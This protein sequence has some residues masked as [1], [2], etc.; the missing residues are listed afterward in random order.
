MR[1]ADRRDARHAASG[2][3]LITRAAP[4]ALPRAERPAIAPAVVNLNFYGVPEHERAAIIRAIPGPA[5]D[6]ATEER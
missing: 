6:A 5:G 2:P 1:W 4:A 3:L